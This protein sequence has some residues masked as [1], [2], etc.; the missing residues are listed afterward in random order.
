MILSLSGTSVYSVAL[1]LP[2]QHR[3]PDNRFPFG[4]GG[5][6]DVAQVDL[7]TSKEI[8]KGVESARGSRLHST[9]CVDA[10]PFIRRRDP[11]YST[12]FYFRC[13]LQRH[14][15]AAAEG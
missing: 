15:G 13:G 6:S 3:L 14:G 5:I 1:A 7:E 2:S 4:G 12:P 8:S 11:L 10:T 9:F